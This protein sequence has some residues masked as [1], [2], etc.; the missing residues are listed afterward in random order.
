MKMVT[1]WWKFLAPERIAEEGNL[2]RIRTPE[3]V[4]RIEWDITSD[5]ERE[6]KLIVLA[7]PQEIF[8]TRIGARAGLFMRPPKTKEHER[9]CW[10]RSV[11]DVWEKITDEEGNEL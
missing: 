6:K 8:L 7:T 1:R 5:L 2:Y 10:V 4:E 3:S 11:D 9:A